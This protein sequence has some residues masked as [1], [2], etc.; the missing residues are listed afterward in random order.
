MEWLQDFWFQLIIE[1]LPGNVVLELLDQ[2]IIVQSAPRQVLMVLGVLV[3]AAIG[4][5]SIVRSI[6]KLASNA[7]KIGLVL[8]LAYYVFVVVLGIDNWPEIFSNFMS[9]W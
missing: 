2:Y 8:G 7:L 9:M 1:W 5:L 3:L 4:A 6:L